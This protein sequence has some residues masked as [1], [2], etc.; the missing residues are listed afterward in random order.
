MNNYYCEQYSVDR[1]IVLI[2]ST[3][4]GRR[5]GTLYFRSDQA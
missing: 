4:H 3:M 2:L 5:C 1:Q